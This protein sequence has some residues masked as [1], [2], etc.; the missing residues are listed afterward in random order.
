MKASRVTPAYSHNLTAIAQSTWIWLYYPLSNLVVT[1]YDTLEGGDW[2][3]I[4]LCIS[5]TLDSD[6]YK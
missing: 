6:F 4:G 3:L 5:S 2:G 1:V